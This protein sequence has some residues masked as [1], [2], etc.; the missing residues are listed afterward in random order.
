[1]ESSKNSSKKTRGKISLHE[2]SDS[3]WKR[4]YEEDEQRPR[5][6]KHRVKHED[7]QLKGIKLKIPTFQ[8]KSDPETYLEW[9]RKIELI[10]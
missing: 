4:E 5:K 7:D 10:L 3:K 1:M 6:H 2:L 9:E 8:G